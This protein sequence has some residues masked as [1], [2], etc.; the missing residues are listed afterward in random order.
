VTSVDGLYPLT[1]NIKG[2]KSVDEKSYEISQQISRESARSESVDGLSYV[3]IYYM[4]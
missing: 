4:C 2:N 3:D 1:D